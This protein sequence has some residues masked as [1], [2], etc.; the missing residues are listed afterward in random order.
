[1]LNPSHLNNNTFLA[2]EQESMHLCAEMPSQELHFTR[3]HPNMFYFRENGIRSNEGELGRECSLKIWTN[4]NGL[5]TQLLNTF[6][7][8]EIQ[9]DLFSSA[10]CPLPTTHTEC[11]WVI[12]IAECWTFFICTVCTN[13]CSSPTP[14]KVATNKDFVSKMKSNLT[15]Y[16][17][18]QNMNLSANHLCSQLLRTPLSK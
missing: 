9:F 14:L 3:H 10:M 18:Y 7:C 15:F 2:H 4:R 8:L 13:L 11:Q 16:K 12:H 5:E 6:L 17:L 1:M